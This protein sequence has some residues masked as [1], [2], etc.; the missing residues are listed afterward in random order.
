MNTSSLK[1]GTIFVLLLTVLVLTDTGTLAQET[2]PTPRPSDEV[3]KEEGSRVIPHLGPKEEGLTPGE[4]G[5]K[6]Y[7]ADAIESRSVQSKKEATLSSIYRAGYTDI[8]EEGIGEDQTVRG[9][10]NSQ[11]DLYEE[12]I[13]IDGRIKKNGQGWSN[14]CGAPSSGT[15]HGC[16]T[17]MADPRPHFDWDDFTAKSDHYFHT[18]GY[19]DDNFSTQDTLNGA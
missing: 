18:S 12:T 9:S 6:V 10:H 19:N 7:H 4:N 15:F 16:A 5:Y 8:W 17:S 1:L 13:D 11:S 2:D 3:T 14:Y